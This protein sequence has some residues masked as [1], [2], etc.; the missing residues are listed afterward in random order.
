MLLLAVMLEV[1]NMPPI[2]DYYVNSFSDVMRFI[3]QGVQWIWRQLNHFYIFPNVHVSLL[4]FIVAITVIGLVIDALFVKWE[5]AS[6]DG[7][8]LPG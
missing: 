6:D 7:L 5:N 1:I 4:Q 8:D 2:Q 3:W